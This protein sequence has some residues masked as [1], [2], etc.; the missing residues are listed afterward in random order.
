TADLISCT[1]RGVMELLARSDISVRGKSV[2]IIGRSNIVGKPLS[3]LMINAGATVTVCNSQTRDI[4]QYTR[5]SDIVVVATGQPKLLT[6]DMIKSGT[7]VIDVGFSVV[8]G[9]ISGDTDYEA[10]EPTCLITPVPGGVG[11][12]TVAMLMKNTF[13]ASKGEPLCSPK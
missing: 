1:P 8:D 11:P 7:V 3:L 13:I 2:T 5:N 10:I 6:L 9:K 12:M 4:G